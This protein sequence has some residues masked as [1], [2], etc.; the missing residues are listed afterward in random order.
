MFFNYKVHC[1]VNTLWDIF[2]QRY[3]FN[4]PEHT[5]VIMELVEVFLCPDNLSTGYTFLYEITDDALIGIP[6]KTHM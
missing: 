3:F 6:V 4:L 5:E 1:N 2:V